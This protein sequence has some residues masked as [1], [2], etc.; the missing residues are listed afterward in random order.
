MGAQNLN[1]LDE[2]KNLDRQVESITD[3]AGLKPIFY[4][5][6]E[7]AKQHPDDFEVQLVVGDIKQHL[8][9]R[10]TRLKE[11]PAAAAPP[12]VAA[13]P[14]A[15]PPPVPPN[16]VIPPRPPSPAGDVQPPRLMSSGQFNPGKP[17]TPPPLSPPPLQASPQ[18]PTQTPPQSGPPPMP[19]SPVTYPAATPPPFRPTGAD[20]IATGQQPGVYASGF[21]TVAGP[22]QTPPNYGQPPQSPPQGY[23]TQ[24]PPQGPPPAYQTQVPPPQ[25]P[26][27]FPPQ[28][29][30]PEPQPGPQAGSQPQRA[31]MNWKRPLMVGALLGAIVAMA[32]IAF[33]VNQARK[34]NAAI[35]DAAAAAI[36]VDVVTAPA[37]ASIRV[38][39]DVK[40]NSPCQVSLPPG[41]Y[42]ITAFLD[43]YDPATSPLTVT[44]GQPSSV[45]LALAPQA[46]SVRILTDLETGKIAVDD[47]PPADLQE[48]QFVMENVTPGAHTVK[49]TGRGSE[50]SFT[51]EVMEAKPPSITGPVNARNLIAV[52]VSSLGSQAHVVTNSGP[53]KLAVNGQAQADAGPAGVDVQGFQPGVDEIVVG[54][55][56]DARNMKESFGP[57]PMLTAFLKSDLNIGTLI[58]SAGE[59]DVKVFLNDKEYRRRTAKGQVRIQTIGNVSVRVAK[60]GFQNEPAQT[61]EIKKGAEV[62]LEFKLKALPQVTSLQIRGATPGAEVLLDQSSIGTIG[63]DGN[64]T[65]N[66]VPPGDHTID[67]RRDQFAPKR[68][69]RSFRTGQ[70]VVIAG[71]DAA[72]ASAAPTNGT[73]KIARTPADATITYRRSDEQQTHELKG[74]QLEVPPGTY[75][76]FTKAPGFADRVDRVQVT[77]G[78]NR[79]L[80]LALN[81]IPAAA[82]PKPGDVTGFAEP[83]AWKKDGDVW[84][85]KGGGFVPYKLG[86]RGVYTFTVELVK[87]GGVF[88]GG[89][90]RWCVQYVDAK[91]YLLYELDKKTFWAEVIEKGKKL[92]RAKTQHN[93]DSQ[94]AFSIQIEVTPE[95][96]VHKIKDASGQWVLLDS[97]AEPGRNFTSGP[98]GFFIQGNDEIGISEFSFVPK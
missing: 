65:Y 19:P 20:T 85:H 27:Q 29:F 78:E 46:Q 91:N 4:R 33:L 84:V 25:P 55:G 62:R 2:L 79:P 93:V 34:R 70:P 49:V 35:K 66:T 36:Q 81:R 43:G 53:M 64:F 37:N 12:P 90:I 68:L 69:Q 14:P 16:V 41:S 39:G 40:C 60:D 30:Q 94:K 38:N 61:A 32:L 71:A 31:A 21:D 47:Q 96:V 11:A 74:D 67:L 97:F 26:Q 22:P 50:A 57:A 52:L 86:P 10:G 82:A 80:Q 51:F 76:V 54:D 15:I 18:G 44:A 28:Q 88:R 17:A 1:P 59:D 92:E 24:I 13:V 6:D 89:R 7:I 45:N 83:D 95:H 56:N 58:V 87:G 73:I 75:M 3:L 23:G 72:L 8:V 98:F 63:A 48:G 42:Q 5:L 77:A 9:N